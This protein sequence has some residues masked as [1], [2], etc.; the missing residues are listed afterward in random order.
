MTMIDIGN[1]LKTITL[2]LSE[3]KLKQ[4][5]IQDLKEHQSAATIA[6]SALANISMRS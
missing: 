4:N 1:D 5:E 6:T 2:R 3:K